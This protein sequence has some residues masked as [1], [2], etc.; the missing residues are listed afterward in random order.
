MTGRQPFES[1]DIGELL[2]EV[3][4]GD[5]APPRQLDLTVAPA[6][7]AVCLKAMATKPE[8]RY[9]T[10][11]ALADDIER[12][13]ADEPVSAWPESPTRR[14]RR[15]ARRNRT[16]A[17]VA[18]A[19]VMVAL[20][21]LTAVI[22]VQ[23]RANAALTDANARLESAN[24]REVKAN[25]DLKAANE[26]ERSR[27]AL[28]Q[29]AI[30]TFHTG[31]SEDLLL[32]QKEFDALLIKLLRGARD[33]YQ[34]LERLLEG[35]ADRESRMSLG[36]AYR[37]VGELTPQIDT[38]QDALTVQAVPWRFSRAWRPRPRTTPKS[39]AI[40]PSAGSRSA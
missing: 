11:R 39:G 38:L 35:Q 8:D 28:S 2:R 24:Q 18:A 32:K 9:P 16:A 10:S 33:F 4:R 27:F 5:Y 31:V 3:Q 37:E 12:W 40:S 1:D 22:A 15:W 25:A 36:H 20:V 29:E 7:E 13:T 6:L 23:N 19:S 30:R 26:R 17:S 21:G 14:I 34:K